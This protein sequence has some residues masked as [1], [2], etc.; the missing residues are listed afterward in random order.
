MRLHLVDGTYEL[1]RA[2]YAPRPDHRAPSGM[3]A[4]ATVKVGEFSRDGVSRVRTQAL[5]HDFHPEAQVTPVGIL[6]PKHDDFH[7]FAV[8]SKVAV[9]A[10]TASPA[11]ASTRWSIAMTR[12]S[13]STVSATL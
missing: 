12:M 3:D 13:R 9:C 2:H 10:G 4:K 1:F 11:L 5:D 6:V 7:L 8:T